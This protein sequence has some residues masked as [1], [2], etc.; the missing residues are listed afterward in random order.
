MNPSGVTPTD[1]WTTVPRLRQQPDKAP[2]FARL[3]RALLTREP[4]PVP[5]GDLFADRETIGAF[6]KQPVSDQWGV[7]ADPDRPITEALF[8]DGL[9]SVDQT[10]QFCLQNGW[11]Y[12]WC[13]STIPFKG[14]MFRPADNTSPEV[15]GGRRYWINDSRGPISSWDDLERYP[16][17]TDVRRINL[18][19]HVTAQRVPEG[20]KVMVIPGGVF[21]WSTWLMGLVPFCY[22]LVDQPDLVDTVIERVS[23]TIYRVV[24]DLVDEPFVGGIFMGDDLGYASGTIVS[25]EILRQKFLPHTKRIVD[26]VRA[27]GKLFVLHTCGDVYAI[28][29]DLIDLGIHAKHSFEDKI[30]PVEDVYR[31][32]GDRVGL[33]G[34]VD[35][36]LLTSGS[37]EDVRRR[38]REILNV[39][40]PGGGYV[41]GTGN[42]VANYVP[43]SNYQAMLDEGRRWNR[44]HFGRE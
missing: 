14:S 34:G 13:F 32:W 18:L 42:S 11:D 28:M 40:G 9:R 5:F 33:V 20:M 43:L 30:Q 26:L 8:R 12:V 27:A 37:E 22:A 36:H 29:D 31:R 35:V 15:Q 6:L 24:E 17:P 16:W 38:T 4:G 23:A 19:P 3:E 10:I 1:L 41:L 44:E 39:C 2:D 21:E 25:H 7:E